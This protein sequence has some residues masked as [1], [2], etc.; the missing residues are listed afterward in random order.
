M[1]AAAV[2]LAA[3]AGRSP[4]EEQGRL[5]A[6]AAAV[7]ALVAAVAEQDRTAARVDAVAVD[8]AT[9]VAVGTRAPAVA[10]AVLVA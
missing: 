10:F 9:E 1:V 8:A 4:E 7:V 5:A 3:T 2:A 6:V